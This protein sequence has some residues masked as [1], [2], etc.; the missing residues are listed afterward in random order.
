MY[1]KAYGAGTT[2]TTTGIWDWEYVTASPTN[3]PASGVFTATNSYMVVAFN[4][5]GRV[6]SGMTTIHL[7]NTGV[8][9]AVTCPPYDLNGDCAINWLDMLQFANNWLVCNR[10]PAGECWQ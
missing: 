9:E 4:L 6:G 7:D 3:G 1:K 2:N 10:D 8:K 5:G